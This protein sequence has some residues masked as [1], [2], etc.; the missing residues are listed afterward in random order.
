MVLPIHPNRCRDWYLWFASF[1]FNQENFT[2]CFISV[3][4]HHLRE[5]NV[6]LSNDT[7]KINMSEEVNERVGTL[8]VVLG[9]FIVQTNRSLNRLEREMREF[10]DEMRGFKD[11]MRG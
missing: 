10:K 5:K 7:I 3:Y 11:E 1:Q 2:C 6:S 4:Y 9:E 8:E